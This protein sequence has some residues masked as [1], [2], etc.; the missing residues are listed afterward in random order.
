VQDNTIDTNDLKDNSVSSTD[1]LDGTV[2]SADIA[3]GAVGTTKLA[4]LPHVR[5]YNSAD[6]SVPTSTTTVLAFNSERWDNPS[7]NQHDNVTNNSRLTAQTAGL[8]TIT[9]HVAWTSN[10][11]GGRGLNLTLN[12]TTRIGVLSL[13]S[14]L[15]SEETVTTQYRLA[16]G[17][18][19][20]VSAW[21]N[22]GSTLNVTAS[23]AYSPEFSMT[24][25]GP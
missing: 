3:N 7:N 14:N 22:S 6:Q 21:Q 18:Y 15:T 2:G 24:W 13:Q 1:I 9:A 16:A 12:G 4:T 23:S 19:V 11:T 5:V 25:M 10:S 20:H 8:Y 17:D